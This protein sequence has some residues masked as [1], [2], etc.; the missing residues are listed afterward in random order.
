LCVLF[1][2][3]FFSACVKSNMP[4]NNNNPIPTSIY[5]LV[6][7]ASNLTLLDSSMSRAGLDSLFSNTGPYTF[8]VATDQAW[9]NAG[10]SDSVVRLFSDSQLN[11]IILYSALNGSI[12]SSQMPVGPNSPVTTLS[13]DSVFITNNSS[14]IFVNGIGLT[15]ADIEATNGLVDAVNLELL[16]PA[17]TLIQLIQSDTLFSFFSAAIIRTSSGQTDVNQILQTGHIFT[18]FLPTNDAFR[19]A[20]YTTVD[21]VNNADPD[22]LAQVLTYHIVP[23]RIFTSDF[24]TTPTIHPIYVADSLTLGV[25]GG[26]IYTVQGSGNVVALP[27]G[28][29]NI[30]AH[31]GV[32]QII[33]QLLLP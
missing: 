32:I 13:G 3:S 4:V 16:P 11:K 24:I 21:S 19:M 33:G 28:Q 23:G 30:M 1:S 20:G 17:G 29:S 18:I 9:A 8:F 7:S 10:L 6:T 27:L 12:S 5:K 26:V 25:L 14:G 31:N 2:C 15:A 22:S